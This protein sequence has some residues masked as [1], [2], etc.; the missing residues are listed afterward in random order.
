MLTDVYID[1]VGVNISCNRQYLFTVS[2][3]EAL[4]IKHFIEIIVS[5]GY[6]LLGVTGI[7]THDS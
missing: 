3:G 4:L 2:Q 7:Q 5:K 6:M 1:T